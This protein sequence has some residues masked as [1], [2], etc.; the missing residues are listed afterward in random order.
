MQTSNLFFTRGRIIYSGN[1]IFAINFSLKVYRKNLKKKKKKER[2][3]GE[4]K[5]KKYKRKMPFKQNILKN[6][7][8]LRTLTILFPAYFFH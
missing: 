3:E 8:K 6:C 4:K 7:H 1:G 2:K 5:I